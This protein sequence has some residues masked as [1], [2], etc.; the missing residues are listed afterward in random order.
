MLVFIKKRSSVNH[1]WFHV[2]YSLFKR[3][4][5]ALSPGTVHNLL[6]SSGYFMYHKVLRSE[7]SRSAHR[8]FSFSVWIRKETRLFPYKLLK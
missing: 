7:I 3:V 2:C 6:R 4:C 1:A 5:K 8:M